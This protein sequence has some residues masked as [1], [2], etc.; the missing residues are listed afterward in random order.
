MHLNELLKSAEISYL[1][2]WTLIGLLIGIVAGIGSIIFYEGLKYGTYYFLGYGAG[3]F[4]PESGK[5]LS[6]TLNWDKPS[7]LWAI[8]VIMTLGGLLSG[9]IVFTI[10]PEAEG[11]G[12]DA[13]IRAFHKEEGVIKKRIP[14]VKMV[15]SILTISTGGSAGRE[16]P[17]AQVAAGFGSII[18]SILK[19][20]AHDRRLA[21]TVGIGAGVGSIFKAPLGGALLSTEILYM[22]DFEKEALIPSVIASIVGFS[23][24]SSFEGFDPVF[25]AEHYPWNIGQIPL[26]VILGVACAV[27]G[28]LYIFSFY[29]TR[30]FFKALRIPVHFKPAVGA[31]IVGVS[32]VILATLIP[33]HGGVAGIGGLAM[34]YGFIQL[35]MYNYLPIKIMLILLF[36]KIFMTSF[37]IG[38]GGSGGV[39]AP[40][41]FIGAMVGGVIGAVFNMFFP[42]IVPIEAIP[43]FV[44][45]GMM[46][47]FGGVARAPVAVIIM[48]S[49]MTNDF[50]LLFPAM[51]AIVGS[52]ILTGDKSIYSEKVPTRLDSPA[53][54]REY[55]MS[56]LKIPTVME[57]TRQEF[58]SVPPDTML[59]KAVVHIKYGLDSLP[60][61]DNG[62]L[63]GAV[64]LKRIMDIPF[65]KWGETR[66][67]DILS[68]PPII[69]PEC[70]LFDVI[71]N[72]D[73]TGIQTFFVVDKENPSR[74]I[75][76]VTRQDILRVYSKR[77]E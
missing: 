19:L 58:I 34:G 33:E 54:M 25:Y 16:G 50:S 26:F 60:V 59:S 18:G 39:F 35:A 64:T 15:A 8:P 51:V 27:I 36:T 10:A 68:D 17:I 2:K 46:A 41:L 1:K 37:T 55:F 23:I 24:F 28:R 38:S 71:K 47:L 4:P 31:A 12:T 7:R 11:H 42:A 62:R 75:G 5:G 20:N 53:H 69:Y 22:N 77:V 67:G 56:L 32:A 70:S 30:D 52:L 45:I 73:N 63:I 65:E 3:F 6:E 48:V 57:A 61:V 74:I 66:V 21:V 13:A 14:L 72:M 44:V 49:E 9:M 43:A 76:I 29:K 40:G